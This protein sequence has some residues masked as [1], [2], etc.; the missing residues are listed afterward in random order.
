VAVMARDRERSPSADESR[1]SRCGMAA[2]LVPGQ[3]TF[4]R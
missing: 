2:M 4:V 3:V 1:C